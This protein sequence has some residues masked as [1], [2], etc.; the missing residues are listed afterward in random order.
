MTPN[1]EARACGIRRGGGK[2]FV[3]DGNTVLLEHWLK[4]VCSG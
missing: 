1:Q 2:T 3:V 4:E